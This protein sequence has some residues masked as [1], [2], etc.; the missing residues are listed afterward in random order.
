MGWREKEHFPRTKVCERMRVR[1]C[2]CVFECE[3]VKEC[4]CESAYACVCAHEEMS[5]GL[6]NSTKIRI[7]T[8]RGRVRER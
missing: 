2:V 7:M 3:C 5:L 4:V 1:V 6:K 8:K